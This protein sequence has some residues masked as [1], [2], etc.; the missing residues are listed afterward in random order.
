[1]TKID[2]LDMRKKKKYKPPIEF[3]TMKIRLKSPIK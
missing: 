3:R 2:W 1:M